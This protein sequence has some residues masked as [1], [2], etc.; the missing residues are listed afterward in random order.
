MPLT[1]VHDQRF[2]L[3]KVVARELR[4]QVM[5]DLKLQAAMEPMVIPIGINVSRGFQLKGKK[6]LFPFLLSC[7]GFRC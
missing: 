3:F 6:L 5:L 2:H 7:K 1:D 4:K